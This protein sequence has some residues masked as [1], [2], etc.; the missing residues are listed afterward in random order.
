MFW[1]NE[2]KAENADELPPEQ[3]KLAGYKPLASSRQ[4]VRFVR[5]AV[6]MVGTQETKPP[7]AR[8]LSEAA[9]AARLLFWQVFGFVAGGAAVYEAALYTEFPDSINESTVVLALLPAV[10]GAL[11]GLVL[12]TI[13]GARRPDGG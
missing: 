11:A 13:W 5:R 3:P 4:G 1:Q 6:A 12:G 7:P 10:P 9:W 2:P 8:R